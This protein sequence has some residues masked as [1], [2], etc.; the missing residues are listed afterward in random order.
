[1]KKIIIIIYVLII[2]SEKS[3]SQSQDTIF[4]ENDNK[5]LN[6]IQ[7]SENINNNINLSLNNYK[8]YFY[9]LNNKTSLD[10]EYNDVT[11]YY[12]KK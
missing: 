9:Y 8:E 3:Y 11:Y 2:L 10:I 7:L 5:F 12:V 4:L 1:M 6:S